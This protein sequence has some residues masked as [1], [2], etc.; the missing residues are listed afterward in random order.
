[1]SATNKQSLDFEKPLLDLEKQLDDLM[2]SSA[3]SDLDFTD[4]IRA[5]EKKIELTKRQV[6]SDLTPWQK[7][8]L[9]RHP[10]RPYS[11]DLIKRIFSEF[12]ELH[13]DRLFRDDHALIGGTATLLN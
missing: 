2:Q 13:G 1:M 12:H 6:Y 3:S 10:N 4:E 7:V 11:P 5:I 8:Q 9:S